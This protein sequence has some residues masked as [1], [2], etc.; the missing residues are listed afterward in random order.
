MLSLVNRAR[1]QA[2]IITRVGASLNFFLTFI[3]CL[4]CFFAA[5]D[6]A[7]A[8]ES[9]EAT[10][11]EIAQVASAVAEVQRWLSDARS[12]QTDVEKNLML[13]EAEIATAALAIR[14]VEV[15]LGEIQTQIT[16][17]Q[18]QITELEANKEIQRDVLASIIRAAY[19]AGDQSAL[20]LVL[21]QADLSTSARLLQ[22]HRIF[23]Q[24][25]LK[26]LADYEA[27]LAN[28]QSANTELL[29]KELE[30]SAQ[31]QSLGEELLAFNTAKASR[32]NALAAIRLAIS[33]RN[34]ELE[35]L[36]IDRAELEALLVQIAEAM[37]S[38]QSVAQLASF[39]ELRGSL[40][41]PVNGPILRR[42]G[43]SYGEGSM[44][45]QGIT[46]AA[47]EGTAVRAIQSGRVVFADWLQG[48]G[49]LVIVDHGEGYMSLYGANQALSK[50]AG[51]WV[52][53]GDVLSTSGTSADTTSG[54][55]FEIRH[56]GQ[57]QNPAL[58]LKK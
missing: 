24:S 9:L 50:S 45:R 17:L 15:H 46:I 5:A 32:E 21:S 2:E 26:S 43:S 22:Y 42:F 20:K 41:A 34:A 4:C 29:A 39:A 10:E 58:W 30:L 53:Q 33:S 52:D 35:Q 11:V 36:Q 27:T 18:S 38:V 49:L 57:A 8:A 28:I 3:I 40:S 6:K 1:K 51:D 25:Q 19:M 47:S 7:V 55:Y 31:Q 13:A 16:T 37:R 48:S 12:E 14:D 54:V 23:T 44:T 56:H